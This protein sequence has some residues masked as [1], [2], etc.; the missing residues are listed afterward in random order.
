MLNLASFYDAIMKSNY[1]YSNNIYFYVVIFVIILLVG[2][3]IIQFL[4]P[5]IVYV[6][7]TYNHNNKNLPNNIRYKYN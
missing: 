7:M 3:I 1:D 2:I 4:N 5:R 6:P